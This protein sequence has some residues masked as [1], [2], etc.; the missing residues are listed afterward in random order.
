MSNKKVKISNKKVKS[1]NICINCKKQKKNHFSYHWCFKCF[2]KWENNI[3]F[4]NQE[5]DF[6]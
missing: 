6:I 5:V 2:K 3:K 4:N 1:K